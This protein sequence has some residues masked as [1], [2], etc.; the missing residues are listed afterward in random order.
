METN[1]SLTLSTL[2]QQQQLLQPHQVIQIYMSL[3]MKENFSGFRTGVQSNPPPVVK[4][5]PP[6]VAK[7]IPQPVAESVPPP[8]AESV[9]PPV[10]KS[11]SSP[12]PLQQMTFETAMGFLRSATLGGKTDNL[13][14]PSA[15][16]VLGKPTR[17]GTG[18]FNLMQSVRPPVEQSVR[19]PVEQ[20]VRSP[21]EQSVRPPMEQSVRPSVEQ[22]SKPPVGQSVNPTVGQSVKPPV[23]QRVKPPV[24]QSVK[25]SVTHNSQALVECLGKAIKALGGR[26]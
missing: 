2:V 22:S 20:S 10:A 9:P 18:S 5:M 4:S 16:V 23:E 7:S 24:V 8:V 21:V 11:V 15:C 19:P 6:P 3:F 12:S 26:M 17:V 13:C 14:S 1:L 25:P